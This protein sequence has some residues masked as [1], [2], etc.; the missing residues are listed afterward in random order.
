MEPLTADFPFARTL[1]VLRSQRT[2]KQT[3]ATT[4]E[5]RY[6]LSSAPPNQYQPQQ[7]LDLI[8]G[9]WG[10][11]EIRN[12]WRRDVLMGEDA[13]R[14]RNPHLLANLALLRSALLTILSEQLHEQSLPEF[15]ENLRSN[16]SRC[17][18]VIA[19]S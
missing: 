14:S 6:Y 12:H 17:L 9:H 13:S 7:W 3:G 1:I 16:P 18:A 19:A 2:L 8:R 10:G 15:R 5:S 4:T 11:V